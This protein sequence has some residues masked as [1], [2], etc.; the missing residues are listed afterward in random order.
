MGTE[1]SRDVRIASRCAVRACAIRL[2][3][4]ISLALSALTVGAQTVELKVASV[5]PDGSG[6]MQE[7]RAGAETIREQ[8][9]GRVVIKFYPGGVMGN[10][11]QVLRKIRVGQL[12]GGGEELDRPQ[13][14]G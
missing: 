10:D 14:P 3:A 1:K 6:W 13:P 2:F 12:Q 11:G 9:D 5:A 8:T 7:M 4:A